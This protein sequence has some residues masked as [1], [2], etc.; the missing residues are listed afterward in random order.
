MREKEKGEKHQCVV[1]SHMSLTEDLTWPATQ[2]YALT[3]NR[4]DDPVVRSLELNPLNHTSQSQIIVLNTGRIVPQL[5][6]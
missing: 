3:G 6:T 5:T 1:A 4:T 2:A